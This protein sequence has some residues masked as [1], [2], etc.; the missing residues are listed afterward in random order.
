MVES[1]GGGVADRLEASHWV[2]D[3]DLPEAVCASAVAAF[4]AAES[5]AVERMTKKGLRE[6]D[7][8]AAVV[9]L[10]VAARDE[11]CRMELVLRHAVPAVRPDDV[12]R[13][14]AEVGGL[15]PPGAR[16][17]RGWPRAP[18]TNRRERSATRWLM[19]PRRVA[20]AILPM[21][22]D[23]GEAAADSTDDV[24]AGPPQ[25][26]RSARWVQVV[27]RP[28]RGLRESDLDR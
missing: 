25:L 2:M 12:I 4:L 9:S 6:F 15:A 23:R 5:V 21:V 18:S 16:C 26:W 24:L 1:P 22:D 14:L 27:A 20:C 8:R 17:S 3:L 19:T 10:S 13:G 11:G 28:R 7:C